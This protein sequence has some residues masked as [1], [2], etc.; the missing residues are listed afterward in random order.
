MTHF[1][2]SFG[3][4]LYGFGTI[5]SL[6]DGC[7]IFWLHILIAFP[8]VSYLFSFLTSPLRASHRLHSV[9]LY[10]LP[11][12]RSPPSCPHSAGISSGLPTMQKT[13]RIK[14]LLLLHEAS[15]K[16]K[17]A[18]HLLI[19]PKIKIRQMTSGFFPTVLCF[20]FWPHFHMNSY[21]AW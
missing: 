4:F 2:K 19:R 3:S 16:M 13:N 8:N 10:Y 6:F 20:W 5:S 11:F 21:S 15:R 12:P 9:F 14:S 7:G 17:C 18:S 1:V